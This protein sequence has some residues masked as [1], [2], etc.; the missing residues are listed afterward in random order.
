[1]SLSASP[2][3]LSTWNHKH[4]FSKTNLYL[5][6]SFQQRLACDEYQTS[7]HICQSGAPVRV[8][9]QDK[10]WQAKGV[11]GGTRRGINLCVLRQTATE[12]SP[13]KNC[14]FDKL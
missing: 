4:L 2:I 6:A 7:Q 13:P 12:R 10:F 14:P 8:P 5:A 3:P 1:M 9:A 11:E